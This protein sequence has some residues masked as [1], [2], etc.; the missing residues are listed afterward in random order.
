MHKFNIK[1]VKV[2]RNGIAYGRHKGIA[3]AQGEVIV[4]FDADARYDSAQALG[5]MA[6]PILDGRCVLTC[7][8]NIFDLTD[9][10][11]LELD[12][13]R[14]PIIAANMLN[15]LQRLGHMAC[16]EPGS[17]NDVKRIMRWV[18]L[19]ICPQHELFN[20]SQR[21]IL[22]YLPFNIIHIPQT[23]V[24]VSARRAKKFVDLGIG[25]LDYCNKAFR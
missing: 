10:T 1:H 20:L 5:Y 7:C 21:I 3:A 11:P 14:A 16:L 12:K 22:K 18:D 4:N 23:A 9:L 2:D 19:Q 6:E 13:M 15:G 25:V 24:Y 8:D 17:A